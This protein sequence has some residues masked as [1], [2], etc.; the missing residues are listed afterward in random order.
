MPTYIC[1][2][3]EKIVK[4]FC[5]YFKKYQK[6]LFEFAPLSWQ[7]FI[8]IMLCIDEFFA[9]TSLKR[10]KYFVCSEE[11]VCIGTVHLALVALAFALSI[12][13]S[14]SH[15]SNVIFKFL[16]NDTQD[17]LYRKNVKVFIWGHPSVCF[18]K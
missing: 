15:L 8:F 9:N 7:H 11:A 1:K 17:V 3:N 14:F 12:V 13:K 18:L 16:T 10:L 4:S 2:Y 6:S 5:R